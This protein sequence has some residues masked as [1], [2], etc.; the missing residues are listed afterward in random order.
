MI[1]NEISNN[2]TNDLLRNIW[3][4]GYKIQRVRGNPSF[5]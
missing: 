3:N 4:S 1:D 2:G 5:I